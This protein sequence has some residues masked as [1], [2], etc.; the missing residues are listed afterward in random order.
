MLVPYFIKHHYPDL[1]KCYI[2]LLEIGGSHSHTLK[3]L[4]QDLGIITLIITDIDT[5]DPA[6]DRTSVLPERN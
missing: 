6:K 5:I 2:A 4:L 3:P 1:A